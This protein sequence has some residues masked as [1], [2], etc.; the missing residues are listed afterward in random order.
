MSFWRRREVQG[1]LLLLPYM[2]VFVLFVIV[3]LAGTFIRSFA[4]DGGLLSNYMAAFAMPRFRLALVHTVLY[5]VLAAV[6]VLALAFPTAFLIYRVVN[7][8]KRLRYLIAM[9][10]ASSMMSLA[11]V[12]LMFFNPRNGLVNKLMPLFGLTPQNWLENPFTAFLCVFSLVFWRGFCFTLF[13][14]LQSMDSQPREI[15]EFA[16]IAG[17]GT[18]QTFIHITLPQ[19]LP[20]LVYVIPTA[21]VSV[22][23]TF[24]PVFLLTYAGMSRDMTNTLVYEFYRQANLGQPG[25]ASAIAVLLLI[26]I[27]ACSYAYMRYMLGRKAVK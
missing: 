20:T 24:E 14:C 25:V 21:V 5:T 27:L 12:W 3:P 6:L 10:Y 22:L 13:N 18:R 8:H 26:P 1:T 17:V 4:G 11:L 19:M 15:Y 23:T 16:A 9:P 2:L 7:R